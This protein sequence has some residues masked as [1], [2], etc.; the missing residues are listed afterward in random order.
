MI[1]YEIEHEYRWDIII[2]DDETQHGTYV[3][4]DPDVI[5]ESWCV[6][7]NDFN[8]LWETSVVHLLDEGDKD[9]DWTSQHQDLPY[10]W[11]FS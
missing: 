2:Y 8:R 3:W 5:G 4:A 10:N 6:V 9:L 1:Q 7:Y 11:L